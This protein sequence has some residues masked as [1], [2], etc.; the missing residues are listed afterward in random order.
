MVEAARLDG[1]YSSTRAAEL[2]AQW[3]QD[4]P[5]GARSEATSR[6]ID[7]GL[8]AFAAAVGP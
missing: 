3:M 2:E 8:A 5:G 4:M 1:H 6:V 7:S